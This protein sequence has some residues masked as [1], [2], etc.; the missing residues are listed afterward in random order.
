MIPA[1][2]LLGLDV[3]SVIAKTV[4]LDESLSE[5]GRWWLHSS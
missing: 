3:G 5:L 1:K 2:M 4:L